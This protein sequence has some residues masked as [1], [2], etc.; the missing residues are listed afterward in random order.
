MITLGIETSTMTGGA[1]L[2]DGDRLVAGSTLNVNITHSERL[3]PGLD[4]MLRDSGIGT[5]QIDVVAVSSGPGSFTGLRVGMSMAKGLVFS[6]RRRLVCVP[7]LEAFAWRF[8]GSRYPVCALFD[9]RKKELYGA[10]FVWND[11]LETFQRAVPEQALSPEGWVEQLLNYDRIMLAGEGAR[12]HAADFRERLGQKAVFAPPHLMS[13]SAEAVAFLGA[14]LAS[15]GAFAD[16]AQASPFYLRKS[17]AE[18]K[19]K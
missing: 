15:Q 3:L 13:P 10:L 8:A 14:K 11:A 2:L 7:T 16:P 19:K 4:R 1:A 9:A 6:S 18:L 12:M 5:E 17:E